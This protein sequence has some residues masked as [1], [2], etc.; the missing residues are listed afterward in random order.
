MTAARRPVV[1]I[2]GG[3]VA[4][5]AAAWELVG[6]PDA[7]TGDDRPVVHVLEAGDRVG[8]RVRSTGFAGRTVDLAADGFLARRPEAVELCGEI[9]ASDELVPVGAT[10]AAILARGR[11]RP[12]PD[13]LA[14]GVPT[15]WLP[16]AR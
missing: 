16:L 8:G 5:L 9:G 11:L 10:G 7:P 12:M 15:R 2:V 1:A 4:G 3:G 6:G 13:G 14:L